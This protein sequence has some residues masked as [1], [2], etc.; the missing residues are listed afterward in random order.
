M[1]WDGALTV[2]AGDCGTGLGV[3]ARTG[4]SLEVPKGSPVAS[5]HSRVL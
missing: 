4:G 1:N 3:P 2:E 5:L